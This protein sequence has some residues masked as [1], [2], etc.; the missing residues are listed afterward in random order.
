[1]LVSSA[2]AEGE[3]ESCVCV[4]AAAMG[5]GVE[6]AAGLA[7]DLLSSVELIISPVVIVLGPI[8]IGIR[9]CRVLPSA[10]VVVSVTVL[11]TVLSRS[12]LASFVVF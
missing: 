3:G 12:L 10:F 4:G 1:M 8:T 9:T 7:V 6:V 2:V 11:V 5:S